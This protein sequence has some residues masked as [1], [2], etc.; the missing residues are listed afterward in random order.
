MGVYRAEGERREKGTIKWIK[1]GN[2]DGRRVC[3]RKRKRRGKRKRNG[4]KRECQENYE[5][6]K[7][8]KNQKGKISCI[9]E[10]TKQEIA[11][12]NKIKSTLTSNCNWKGLII[13]LRRREKGEKEC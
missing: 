8:K 6:E 2:K 12:V 1:E 7:D 3:E 11:I 9:T 5:N 10:D 4:R 13:K